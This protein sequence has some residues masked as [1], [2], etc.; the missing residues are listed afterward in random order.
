M[1]PAEYASGRRKADVVRLT[2]YKD[3]KL[4]RIEFAGGMLNG[5]QVES[6][7]SKAA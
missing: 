3:R 1:T 2:D 7:S 5:Y 6:E 4:R